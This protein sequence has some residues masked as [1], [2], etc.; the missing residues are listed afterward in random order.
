MKRI[1]LF[2]LRAREVRKISQTALHELLEDFSNIVQETVSQIKLEVSASLAS[3]G[4]SLAVFDG[5]E[6]VFC[7][8]SKLEPFRGLDSK[9]LQEAFYREHFHLLVG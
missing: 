6:D 9:H 8:R 2:L 3:R 5:I 1:G 4:M 7:D